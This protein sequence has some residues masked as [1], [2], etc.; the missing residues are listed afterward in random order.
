MGCFFYRAEDLPHHQPM[1][2]NQE[3]L[4]RSCRSSAR[5]AH[6]LDGILTSFVQNV[7]LFEPMDLMFSD[8]SFLEP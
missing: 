7:L 4:G 6:P 8:S 1:S 3:L 5:V 2:E